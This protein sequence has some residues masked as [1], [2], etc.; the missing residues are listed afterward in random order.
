MNGG[1][2]TT[3]DLLQQEKENKLSFRLFVLIGLIFVMIGRLQES[4]LLLPILAPIHLGAIFLVLSIPVIFILVKERK[5]QVLSVDFPEMKLLLMLFGIGMLSVLFAMFHLLSLLYMGTVFIKLVLIFFFTANI[6]RSHTDLRR[7]IWCYI[8]FMIALA[9][10]VLFYHGGVG[11]GPD[12]SDQIK[13]WSS[14]SNA[15]YDP[16]DICLLIVVALPFVVHFIPRN[17]GVKKL[18]LIATLLLFFIAIVATSSRGGFVG[19][20]A[21]L[22]MMLYR[23]RGLN[24]PKKLGIVLLLTLSFFLFAP[25][26]FQERIHGIGDEDYNTLDKF[27]RVRIWERNLKVIADHPLFGVGPGG[28]A[29]AN[30]FLFGENVG[31]MAWRV[32]AHNSYMLIAVEFGC[33]GLIVYLAF[34]LK[35]FARMR[36]IL[37]ES[38]NNPALDDYVWFAH[39]LEASLVGFMVCAFFLSFCYSAISYFLVGLGVAYSRILW[40]SGCLLSDEATPGAA[41]NEKRTV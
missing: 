24:F 14:S 11:S 8:I 30:G 22:T 29:D 5:F 1:T 4:D 32:T 15:T 36:R 13:R 17:K 10:P 18:I 7:V 6:V 34:L 37:K 40:A 28:F 41:E 9:A 19:L 35:S 26:S 25:A 38:V 16:N 12:G 39:A 2:H 23:S 3:S 31:G 27:G 21:V 33:I 20:V